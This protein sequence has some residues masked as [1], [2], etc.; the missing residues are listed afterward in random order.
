MADD[1]KKEEEPDYEAKP[2]EGAQEK[3]PELPKEVKE[4]LK[5]IKEKLDKFS[6]EIV[7]KFES[8]IMGVALLPP[9][10]PQEGEQMDKNKIHVLVLVDDSDSKKMTKYELNEKLTKIIEETA[11]GIDENIAPQV[12]LISDLWQ[13]CYDGK[14]EILQ[15]IAMAAP[16]HD[17][18]M[19]SALKIA[20]IH[21]TMTLKK[22]EKYIVA[23]VL[24]GS[25]VQGK[26]TPESDIDVFL[27]IDDTDVKRMTRAELKDKLRTII[28]GMGLEAGELTGIKNKLNIQVYIL[29]DFW[30]NIKEANPIIF[31]FLR[32][33][34]PLYDRGVFMPWKQLLKM[35]RIKPSGEAIEMY[36]STGEQVLKRIAMK[37]NEMAMEDI[38]Y[39]ILTPSQAALMMYGVPPPTPKETPNVMR[40]IFV[41]K[42]K[43]LEDSYIKILERAIQVRKQL[44]HGTLK[45]VSGKELDE[46]TSDCDKY[47]VRLKKLFSQIEKRKEEESMVQ[48]YETII[49]IVRDVLRL[50]G[51]ERAK[52]DEVI[53]LFNNAMVATGKI[54]EK[55]ARIM[56]DVLKAKKD[57]DQ[58][59]LT[60]TE[61]AKVKKESAQFIRFVIEYMQRKKGREFD[62]ARIRVKHGE[63]FGEVVLLGEEAFIIHDVNQTEKDIT[64]AKVTKEGTFRDLKESNL[65]ELEKALASIEMPPKV[66]LKEKT[67]ENL[68]TIFGRDVEVMLNY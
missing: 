6:K 63:T 33:G 11:K 48:I 7:N 44:E 23:Y 45:N 2:A 4:K 52:E 24:A 62:R 14:Y 46:L 68:K 43:L 17:T 31:T 13:A 29:T 67:L 55:Y 12:L 9:P 28:I 53:E 26:A 8:Y 22:F 35:G 1:N 32:D 58:K 64:R 36:M 49:S 16:I 21:K 50:E 25:L 47:L 57:Y 3:I 10:K 34:I 30:E 61:V 65:E 19:L 54:P 38:F 41:Q 59:K 51:I 40:E 15:M 5:K 18:G 66:Y 39:A 27:V 42:E 60:K 20:E 37:I 56:K